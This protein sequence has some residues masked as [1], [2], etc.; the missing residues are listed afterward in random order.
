M[1]KR[2]F[3]LTMVIIFLP[4]LLT[5][6]LFISLLLLLTQGKPVFFIQSR[7]GLN[8]RL[9]KM[10]KFRTMIEGN[11]D[12]EFDCERL[13]WI[14]KLLRDTSL[15]ELP[16]LLNVIKGD[17]SLVGPRPLLV[18]YL[19]HYNEFQYRRHTVKPGITGLAQI[20]GRNNLS[21]E[22]R[23]ILDVWYVDNRT[24]WLDL[25]ILFKTVI[26]VLVKEN[27]YKSENLTMEKFVGSKPIH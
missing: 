23:F 11:Q 20:N 1:I 5:M 27:I 7:P 3:D 13:T 26:K 15:D 8:G 18:E 6:L 25:K 12:P 24:I 10:I 9:F 17:M 14:G 19:P 21:W 22:E 2:I 4:F 16:E